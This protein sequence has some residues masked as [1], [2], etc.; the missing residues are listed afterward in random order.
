MKYPPEPS[1]RQVRSLRIRRNKIM[2][3]IFVPHNPSLNGQSDTTTVT[4]TSVFDNTKTANSTFITTV[5]TVNFSNLGTGLTV[6]NASPNAGQNVIY[7]F[8]FTNN[9]AVPAT[10]VGISDLLS[11]LT[12]V[13]STTTS[14]T[15]NSS[16]NP[17]LFNVG[18]INP[19]GSVTVTI[20]LAVPSG[21]TTGTVYNNTMNV[22]YTQPALIPLRLQVTHGP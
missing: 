5:N 12:Y 17:V 20:T 9:G 16:G 19:G 7:T 10:G 11:G 21:A 4:A 6:N 13:S 1:P 3:R 8:T 15:V 2:V 14:G 18:T 22:T